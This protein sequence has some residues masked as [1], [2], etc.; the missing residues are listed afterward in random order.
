MVEE[1]IHVGFD[2]SDNEILSEGFNELNLYKYFDDVSD[3]EV[4]A[5]DQYEDE[6]K[7]L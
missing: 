5:N 1:N 6:K 2:E 3:D 4:D 7:N